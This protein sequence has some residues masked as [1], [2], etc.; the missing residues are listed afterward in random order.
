MV[1]ALL[2]IVLLAVLTGMMT[3]EDGYVGPLSHIAGGMFGEAH[4]G[5]GTFVMVLV[6][7]HVLGVVAH[8]VISRENLVRS[9]VTGLKR[10]P[11]GVKAVAI[12]PVGLVRPLIALALAMASILYFMR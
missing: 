7:A 3:R 10:V 2:G 6:G 12:N 8:A 11:A 5:F 4:E 9:M 1:M